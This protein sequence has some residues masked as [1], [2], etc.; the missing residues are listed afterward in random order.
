[1]N[2]HLLI[3]APHATIKPALHQADCDVFTQETIDLF[4]KKRQ[5]HLIHRMYM[6]DAA[7]GYWSEF[8]KHDGYYVTRSELSLIRQFAAAVGQLARHPHGII[9]IENGP[10]TDSAII[11]KSAVFF[12]AMK[13]LHTYVGRDWSPA[14]IHN[15]PTV[16]A[17]RLPKTR[18][19]ADLSNYL[20]DDVPQDLGKGRKVMAE[21]GITRGNMEGFATDP[22]PAHVLAADMAFHRSQLDIGDLY[23]LTFDANQDK[24]SVEYAYTSEW[25]TQWGRELFRTMQRELP[26]EGDFD[27]EGF[28]FVPI[29]HAV[30]YINTNNMVASKDMDFT[31]A[32]QPVNVRKGE[33]FA[34]T[35][36]YK[37]PIEVFNTIALQSG[38]D[39]VALYQDPER[40]MTMPV[41]RAA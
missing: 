19:V 10:G 33:A 34:I 17:D 22:F 14:I 4:T 6:T 25:L 30:S 23:V 3:N 39:V 32:G 24:A 41:L 11:N 40:R 8:M 9:G 31:I 35:N 13:G 7:L 36:S 20:K 12:G 38:F 1:M 18:I 28:D 29:F 21:F 27:P 2:Q 26:I 37:T 5:G 16:L 15:V